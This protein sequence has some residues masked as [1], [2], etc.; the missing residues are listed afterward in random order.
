MSRNIGIKTNP[1]VHKP[2]VK[3]Q[4]MTKYETGS[5]GCEGGSFEEL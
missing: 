2:M 3:T 4:E 5:V 1:W